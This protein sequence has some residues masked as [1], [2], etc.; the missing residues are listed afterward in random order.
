[1]NKRVVVGDTAWFYALFFSG[2]YL[3][4]TF[5]E[6]KTN[7]KLHNELSRIEN[8]SIGTEGLTINEAFLIEQNVLFSELEKDRYYLESEERRMQV[9]LDDLPWQEKFKNWFLETFNIFGGKTE[10]KAFLQRV[11]T[12]VSDVRSSL[13]HKM[14][15]VFLP[16]YESQ[17]DV[18]N[19]EIKQKKEVF[20]EGDCKDLRDVFPT[21]DKRIACEEKTKI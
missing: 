13:S 15:N 9:L 19:V 8:V 17:L 14:E 4:E 7:I 20:S 16:Y 5:F 3:I 2:S 18:L 6:K 21:D 11:K 10:A 1:M 12:R